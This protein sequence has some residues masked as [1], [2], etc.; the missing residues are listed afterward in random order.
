MKSDKKPTP[1]RR[2]VYVPHARVGKTFNL[3]SIAKQSFKAECDIN[4]IMAKYNKTGFI[5]HVSKYKGSYSDLPMAF[6]YHESLL[7]MQSA[8][9][10]FNTLSADIRLKFENDPH[11]FLEFIEDPDNVEE[12]AALGL[13]PAHAV[14][15]PG[16]AIPAQEP[17]K[18]PEIPPTGDE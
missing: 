4:H 11:L 7:A 17:D 10:A 15:H 9:D 13:G 8:D 1:N 2:S 16:P 18:A 14:P 12:I 6:D 5:E 3:P